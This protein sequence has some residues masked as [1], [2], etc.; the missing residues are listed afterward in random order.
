[1]QKMSYDKL[2]EKLGIVVDMIAKLTDKPFQGAL[3]DELQTLAR[4]LVK[5]CQIEN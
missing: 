2:Y 5:E 4:K 1:M 3:V